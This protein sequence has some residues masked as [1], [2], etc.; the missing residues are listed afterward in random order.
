MS[1]FRISGF[2]G[3]VPRLAKQ[4]L[5]PYQAQ[6]ATNCDLTSGDLRPRS[7]PK[8]VFAP[9]INNDIVSMFRME[10]DGNEKWLAW[11]RDVDVARSPVAGNTSRRF[12][13]TGDG[14]PRV[15]DYETA[16]RGTGPYPSGCFVLGVTPPLKAPAI[17][18]SGG[19]GAVVT[20]A[21]VCTFV[22]PWGEESKP[23]PAATAT[24]NADAA[25][26]LSNLDT[27]PPNSGTVTGASRNTPLPGHVEV[28]LDS[29]FGL[30]AHEE[31]T[32]ASVSGMTDLNATFAI[33]SV[34][35][36]TNK[37]VVPLSTTQIY[38]AGGTWARKA[39]H[40]THGMIKRIYRTLSTSE[41]TEY[42]YVATIPAIATAYTDTASDE[43][44]ALGEI[45]PSA[46][47]EMPPADLKGILILP[48]GVAAGFSG[49]E[50]HFSEPFKPYAWP[51]AYRQTYDQDIVAIG[52]TGTTLVG[53][54]QGNP[55]TITG[56]EPVTMGGGMEKLGVAWPCMAKRGVASFAFGVGYPAPQG[57][58]IIGAS[59]DIV[60]NDLFTQKEWSELNPRTFI[61]ASADNRYYCGY[62]I[63]D[64]SLM[65][66]IDKTER[67]SFIR[68]NQRISCIWTDPAT[69]RLYV[70]AEKKIYEWE[71]DA[72]S[73]LSYEWK[74]KKFVTTPPVNYGAAKIDA[75]FDV[76]E[77]ELAA[78]QAAHDSA[79]AANR[80]VITQRG[81]D[82]GLA[83]PGLG[84]YAIGGDA[85]DEIPPLIADS[86]QFQLWADGALKFTKKVSNN[87]A[88]RLP[89]GYKADN[90]E[91]VLSGNVKVTGAVLAE[92]MDGLKQA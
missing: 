39:P 16:T 35:A 69:G 66:V 34:N 22:T 77:A 31:I 81:M 20:R 84:E 82:D 1:A 2:S 51:T 45:L 74:S 7:G 85:M 8:A 25:W 5:A 86:L 44:V 6:I 89:A 27:A 55:F 29:V 47:W 54:T 61:A 65:F 60:T 91:I 76:S 40:N 18:I 50:V 41:A 57:M 42:H 73:K 92:T 26:M 88:F 59:S 23:S 52:F 14:E 46:N 19:A 79:I 67:A 62:T 15:S 71:G 58:V 53:M 21:Y 4:L 11:D 72:G 33:H 70:A 56:V 10:K 80:A 64:S 48:N 78:T 63:D 68:I 24:A 37:I 28:M 90:V 36:G 30:R 83:D 9:V 17:S 13:Y 3:L 75:D 87:R 43:D 12:Y 38:I 32:F 49:N